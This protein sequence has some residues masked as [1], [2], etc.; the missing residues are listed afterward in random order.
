MEVRPLR[1]RYVPYTTLHHTVTLINHYRDTR[2]TTSLLSYRRA[3]V[4]HVTLSLSTL[5][6]ARDGSKLKCANEK[7]VVVSTVVSGIVTAS[8]FFVKS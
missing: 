4:T 7:P 2:Y 1:D 5:P 6:F 3:E 8:A